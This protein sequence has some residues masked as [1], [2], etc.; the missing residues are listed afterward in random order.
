LKG[1]II[2]LIRSQEARV[3]GRIV[4]RLRAHNLAPEEPTTGEFRAWGTTVENAGE[5]LAT[6][7]ADLFESWESQDLDEVAFSLWRIENV[8]EIGTSGAAFLASDVFVQLKRAKSHSRLIFGMPGF[9]AEDVET[10]AATL[11]WNAVTEPES[12]GLI[13][14]PT[15][16]IRPEWEDFLAH[17]SAPVPSGLQVAWLADDT[18]GP[19]IFWVAR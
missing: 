6:T 10:L 3:I 19:P 18:L 1:N 4:E 7:P 2:W 11:L 15:A 16:E 9:T 14:D 5:F 13:V 17:P 12:L 8:G